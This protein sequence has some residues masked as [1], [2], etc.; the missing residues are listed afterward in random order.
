M[1][2]PADDTQRARWVAITFL[3]DTRAADERL[4]RPYVCGITITI[5]RDSV[6]LSWSTLD[7]APQPTKEMTL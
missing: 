5:E 4:D 7:T 6:R 2:L 3:V 1:V